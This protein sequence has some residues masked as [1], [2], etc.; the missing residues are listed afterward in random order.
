MNSPETG[1]R[2]CD[3][4]EHLDSVADVAVLSNMITSAASRP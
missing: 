4:I 3:Y 1:D 2:G